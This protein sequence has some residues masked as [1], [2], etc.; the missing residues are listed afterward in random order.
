MEPPPD[1][2]QDRRPA[3]RTNMPPHSY[4]GSPAHHDL[5][6][7]GSSDYAYTYSG[8]NGGSGYEH[9]S[10]GSYDHGGHHDHFH[11]VE[12]HGPHD[13]GHYHDDNEY[14]ITS[15]DIAFGFL[16]FMIILTNLQS[17]LI[18]LSKSNNLLGV[19]TSRKRRDASK[20]YSMS[21][22][23]DGPLPFPTKIQTHTHHL[24]EHFNSWVNKPRD[25]IC[26]FSWMRRTGC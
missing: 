3:V 9:F 14:Q 22:V 18:N 5:K 8:V 10:G 4:N 6:T 16:T 21:E 2:E 26:G 15:R 13:H 11:V 25:M 23:P 12:D 1:V 20:L 17:A 7:L 19:I 24:K